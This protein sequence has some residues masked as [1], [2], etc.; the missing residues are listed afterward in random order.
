MSMKT[1]YGFRTFSLSEIPAMAIGMP[2]LLGSSLY[3]IE[4]FHED[5]GISITAVRTGS[6][7]R[8]PREGLQ[9]IKFVDGLPWSEP[10][11]GDYSIS[12]F[13]LK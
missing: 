2:V 8:L 7:L 1:K 6:I 9:W 3:R 10:V 13:G 11:Q 4:H 12:R 5:G